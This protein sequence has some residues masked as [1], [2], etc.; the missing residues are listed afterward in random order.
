MTKRPERTDRGANYGII[1]NVSARAVA[2]GDG[3]RATSDHVEGPVS[4]EAFDAALK[5]LHDQISRLSLTAAGAEALKSDLEK[6]RQAS[7]QK[8]PDRTQAAGLLEGLIGKLKM[9]GVLV[10][11]VKPL[12]GPLRTVA[13]M[14]GVPLPF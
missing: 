5:E 6:L 4:R 10:E 2:V 14:F 9:V 8:T 7:T 3:A 12:S 13:S 11:T 1:G